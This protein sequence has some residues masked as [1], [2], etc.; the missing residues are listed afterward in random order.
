MNTFLWISSWY[1][2][3]MHH[4]LTAGSAKCGTKIILV[5]YG[6]CGFPYQPES[7]KPSLPI[8]FSHLFL[9]TSPCLPEPMAQYYT[10]RPILLFSDSRWIF[11]VNFFSYHWDTIYFFMK[12]LHTVMLYYAMGFKLPEKYINSEGLTWIYRIIFP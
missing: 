11:A 2:V 9:F 12:N 8:T 10:L 4:T 7:L 1:F 3:D 5:A 6:K